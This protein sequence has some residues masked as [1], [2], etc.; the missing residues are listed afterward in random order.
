M[1]L[2]SWSFYNLKVC[3]KKKITMLVVEKQNLSSQLQRQFLCMRFANKF[4]TYT[5]YSWMRWF[6]RIQ[7]CW[8]TGASERN[9]SRSHTLPLLYLLS[10]IYT[11]FYKGVSWGELLRCIMPCFRCHTELHYTVLNVW[12]TAQMRINT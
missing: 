4:N 5:C 2:I 8:G 9:G 12:S 1:Q 11:M 6:S 3:H 7:S 10:D